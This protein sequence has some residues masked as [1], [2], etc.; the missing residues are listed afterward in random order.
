MGVII[1]KPVTGYTTI[2]EVSNTGQIKSL[3][4]TIKTPTG[5]RALKEKLL[6]LK[7]NNDGYVHVQLSKE[8]FSTSLLVHRLVAEAFLDK[9]TDRDHVNH[10]NCNKTD[11]RVENLEWISRSEN[12]QHAIRMGLCCKKNRKRRVIDAC[13]GVTYNS[14]KDAAIAKNIK[15]HT[16]RKCL[17]GRRKNKTGL[18]VNDLINL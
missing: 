3:A 4:R 2:Y 14:I 7:V 15:Y 1:W 8:G 16:L 12:M 18:F 5:A 10:K 13:K 17:S 6:K 11:N 9:Q